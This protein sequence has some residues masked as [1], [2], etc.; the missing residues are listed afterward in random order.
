MS[1]NLSQVFLFSLTSAMSQEPVANLQWTVWW[2]DGQSGPLVLKRAL[3]V[4]TNG[5]TELA[6][7]RCC[8]PPPPTD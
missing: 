7:D 2:V 8:R 5:V 6:A 4:A 3:C 1:R